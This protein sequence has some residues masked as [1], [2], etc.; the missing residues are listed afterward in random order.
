[1]NLLEQYQSERDGLV[2][3]LDRTLEGIEGRDLSDIEQRSVTDARARIEALDAQI[4]LVSG[5]IQTRN[6]GADLTAVLNRAERREQAPIEARSWGEQFVASGQFSDY[7]GRGTSASL[8]IESRAL[9]TALADMADVLPSK[10]RVDITPPTST[11]LLDVIN[12]VNVSQ[13]GIE[14]V[15]WSKVAGGAAK[16]A[17]KSAKP[18]VEFAPAITPYTLDTIAAYTQMTRQMIEDAPAV[19]STIDGMLRRE[20]ALKLESEAAAS[21]VAATLPTATDSSLLAAIR[22]GVGVVQAAG[23]NPNAVLLNPADWADLDIALLSGTSAP[24][25]PIQQSFWGLRVIA[26]NSQ[27]AGTATVGDMSAGVQ[28][29]S[30]TGVNLYITDSHADTFLSNVFTLL[31][32]ARAKTIV[33]RPQALVEC[34]VA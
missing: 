21:L 1:M 12:T 9:P 33:T 25:T 14:T 22:Q 4:E 20:V 24:G 31:A 19:R 13:N 2:A 28:R 27:P 3:V 34:S 7:R 16:V 29:Y 15:V 18:S 11:P 23:Y 17:E 6:A 5:A 10:A 26:A 32:E 30:R 8:V